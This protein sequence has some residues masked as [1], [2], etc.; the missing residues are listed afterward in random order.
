MFNYQDD[1]TGGLSAISAEKAKTTSNKAKDNLKRINDRFDRGI[2]TPDET[3]TEITK[4]KLIYG[5]G[6]HSLQP[7]EVEWGMD[8]NIISTYEADQYVNRKTSPVKFFVGETLK[9]GVFNGLRDAANNTL[10]ALQDADE[11]LMQGAQNLGQALNLNPNATPVPQYKPQRYEL[12]ETDKPTTTY[13]NIVSTTAQV[14]PEFLAVNKLLQAS[15][16]V[17]L[18]EAMKTSEWGARFPKLA[19]T[20]KAGLQG[21]A[22]GAI[23]DATAFDP[24]QPRL[25][26]I[27]AETYPSLSTPITEYLKADPSD[28]ALEGRA[29]NAIEGFL[30]GTPLGIAADGIFAGLKASKAAIWENKAWSALDVG[31]DIDE[32]MKLRTQ[33]LLNTEEFQKNLKDNFKKEAIDTGFI[34]DDAHLDAV[35]ELLHARATTWSIRN[36]RPIEDYYAKLKIEQGE[37]PSESALYSYLTMDEWSRKVSEYVKNQTGKAVTI[38]D[39]ERIVPMQRMKELGALLN[40]RGDLLEEEVL[41]LPKKDKETG[42]VLRNAK[43]DIVYEELKFLKPNADYKLTADPNTICPKRFNYASSIKTIEEKLGKV[44]TSDELFGLARLLE[45]SGNLSPCFYC[46][47][48]GGR[49]KFNDFL[50]AMLVKHDPAMDYLDRI[51]GITITSKDSLKQIQKDLGITEGLAKRLVNEWDLDKELGRSHY[52]ADQK[53]FTDEAY[54]EALLKDP[55]NTRHKDFFDSCMSYAGGSKANKEKPYTPYRG[56]AFDINLDDLGEINSRAGLRFFS[57]TD[58]QVNHIVDLMQ[59]ISDLA[60]MK[61]KAH[62]YTKIPEFVEIFGKTGMKINMSIAGHTMPDGS[63]IADLSHGMDHEVAKKLAEGNPNVSCMFMAID[64]A[65]VKWALEQDWI[66][67]IIPFHSSGMSKKQFESLGYKNYNGVQFENWIKKPTDPDAAKPH[68]AKQQTLHKNDRETYLRLCEEHGVNPLFKNLKIDG[69]S[70]TEHPNYMKL[71][72]DMVTPEVEQRAV[73]ADFNFERAQKV[74]EDWQK[75]GGYAKE[76]AVDQ[77][78]VQSLKGKDK[79]WMFDRVKDVIGLKQPAKQS[80]MSG[81]TSLNQLPA[82]FKTLDKQGVWIKGNRNFDLGCGKYDHSDTFLA[83]RGVENIG[84]DPV[85]R[86]DESVFAELKQNP[87]DTAT[88]NNVLNVVKEEGV[89]TQVIRQAADNIKPE[90]TAYFLIYEGDK[91]AVGR[92]SKLKDGAAESWQNNMKTRDYVDEIKEAFDDVTVKSNMIIARSPVQE[93]GEEIYHAKKRGVVLG[94]TEFLENGSSLVKLFKGSD[95]TTLLH[96][97]GHV[98]RK[99]LDASELAVAEKWLKVKDGVWTRTHHEKFVDG[100]IKYLQEGASPVKEM[101]GVFEYFRGWLTEVYHSLIRYKKLQV[102][103]EVRQLFDGMLSRRDWELTVDEYAERKGIMDMPTAHAEHTKIVDDALKKGEK[104]HSNIVDAHVARGGAIPKERLSEYATEER[105]AA[106]TSAP[107]DGSNPDGTPKTFEEFD[108]DIEKKIG[109]ANFRDLAD[110]VMGVASGEVKS[111]PR[112]ADSGEGWHNTKNIFRNIDD[113]DTIKKTITAISEKLGEKGYSGKIPK[114]QSFDEIEKDAEM[115]GMSPERLQELAASTT[116]LPARVYAARMYLQSYSEFVGKFIK[117]A[118]D[119][120]DP[121]KLSEA[122]SHV[123]MLSQISADVSGI[124]TGL[125]R[126]L[127]QQRMLVKASVNPEWLKRWGTGVDT[128]ALDSV[129]QMT[130]FLKT[131]E[132]APT[133]ESKMKISRVGNNQNL[134]LGAMLEMARAA[135]MSGTKTQLSNMAASTFTTVF[136]GVTSEL[137][138][139]ATKGVPEAVHFNAV[140]LP[141]LWHGF[142]TALRIPMSLINTFAESGIKAGWQSILTDPKV[143]NV[144]KTLVGNQSIVDPMRR[145]EQAG[146]KQTKTS[147]LLQ[148]AGLSEGKADIVGNT[149]TAPFRVI[150]AM[151]ELFKTMNYHA[152]YAFLAYNDA[153]QK[154]LR[155]DAA[156]SYVQ[157]NLDSV[158]SDLANKALERARYNTLNGDVS[159]PVKG[160]LEFLNTNAFGQGISLVFAPF[161]KTPLN[162]LKLATDSSPLG[163]LSSDFRKAMSEGGAVRAERIAQVFVGASIMGAGWLMYNNGKL[164]GSTLPSE[165][166]TKAGARILENSYQFDD[167]SQF[168]LSRLAPITTLLTMGADLARLVSMKDVPEDVYNNRLSLGILLTTKPLTSLASMQALRDL[169]DVL[170]GKIDGEKF[171][172]KKTAAFVPYSGL[173]KEDWNFSAEN[174]KE[175]RNWFDGINQLFNSDALPDKRHP[176]YGTKV[177]DDSIPVV[178]GLGMYRGA[179]QRDAVT[180]ELWRVGVSPKPLSDKISYKGEEAKLDSKQYTRMND[181][182]AEMPVKDTLARVINSDG[183]KNLG[184]NDEMRGKVLSGIVSFFH[185]SAQKKLLVEDKAPLGEI[186]N[187]HQ[188]VLDALNGYGQGHFAKSYLGNNPFVKAPYQ[189]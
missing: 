110:H 10:Q 30:I 12:L 112:W 55:A 59:I 118:R 153:W 169:S 108:L 166:G 27:L 14:M 189:Q 74:I 177:K 160:L 81:G 39:L 186:M 17:T 86:P 84:Y 135:L 71:V 157:K 63:I 154:G 93:T 107:V 70:V 158:N 50:S 77:N 54:R 72:R 40:S 46:Y 44:L 117:E 69:K 18:L 35:T 185:S 183:Y 148:K 8:H 51:G 139:L 155:G 38:E 137:S 156:Q 102:S 68:L 129:D 164:T 13:G 105:R 143:G 94:S 90:G 88:I 104:V 99:D 26:N 170:Q 66:S 78:V 31:K 23:V 19:W 127:A 130:L 187:K 48:E 65:Q 76:K 133:L 131:F 106:G 32:A 33:S 178:S 182:L 85:H 149:V 141:A 179:T 34:K 89:R 172:A 3:M 83:D 138:V 87:A 132:E 184:K 128:V 75:R 80:I 181:I 43:G 150:G 171:V 11:G 64:D 52:K 6:L 47:V 140:I 151:D 91:S 29:K 165:Y 15:K 144:Y 96:E 113:A 180:D 24:K 147:A 168:S 103:P 163:I 41:R 120:R 125:G 109:S 67:M 1:L 49:R 167:G 142:S 124:G 126:A 159:K 121:L 152:E 9:R 25:S 114:Y 79:G 16:G 61:S 176:V 42:D 53:L 92:V 101:K 188:E 98:F 115:L 82:S 145:T 45:S 28:S 116:D 57:S 95:T 146:T 173:I 100:F 4:H 161:L 5:D 73:T 162:I 56:D 123:K 174:E 22:A 134:V 175:I 21:S 20:L 119:S 97:L 60:L 122:V 136:K 2:A 37:L 7:D 111:A 58:F 62:A 36:E